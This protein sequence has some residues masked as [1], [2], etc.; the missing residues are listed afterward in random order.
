[1]RQREQGGRRKKD[2]HMVRGEGGGA[3]D[4]GQGKE[5]MGKHNQL[6]IYRNSSYQP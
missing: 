5:H 2:W 4:A 3:E 6:C 1:M